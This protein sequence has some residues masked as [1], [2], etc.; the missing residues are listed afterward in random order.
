MV[1]SA[2]EAFSYVVREALACNRP[3]LATP[4]GAI[5]DVV[6]PGQSGWLTRSDAIDDLSAVLEDVLGRRDELDRMIRDG[7]PR[8]VFETH[9]NEGAVPELYLVSPR[10]G[11]RGTNRG[12][13]GHRSRHL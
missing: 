8:R 9:T 5:P 7:L 3:V 13:T 2:W 1:P 10:A 6:E 11:R 4:V 12:R